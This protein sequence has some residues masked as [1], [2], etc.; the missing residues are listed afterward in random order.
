MNSPQDKQ[1]KYFLSI[2]F[3]KLQGN[4]ILGEVNY[5]QKSANIEYFIKRSNEY[6]DID[7]MENYSNILRINMNYSETFNVAPE[8]D[9]NVIFVKCIVRKYP[10]MIKCLA[11]I[12]FSY[13]HE[14]DKFSWLIIRG[15]KFLNR[16]RVENSDI[17]VI[18]ETI[19]QNI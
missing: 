18:L 3:D 1:F 7:G 17:P 4:N 15:K 14:F 5:S 19:S 13:D 2:I 8:S 12:Y 6:T 11:E 10:G 16:N 9:G